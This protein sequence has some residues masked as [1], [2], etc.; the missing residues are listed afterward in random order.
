MSVLRRDPT[1]GRWVVFGDS[2]PPARSPGDPC[3]F[4]EGNE[5]MTP[6]EIVAWGRP[7]RR[8]NGPGW[9]V[10]VVP[11]ARPLLRIEA[12]L[13]RHADGIYD[14]TSGTGAHEIV[15][16]TAQHHHSLSALP[17]GQVALVLRAWAERMKDLKR[18]ARFRSIFLFKNQGARAGAWL[19]DH[20]H[21]QII[22]LPVI[23]KALKEMLEGARQHFRLK[24]RC[25]FC[26]ILREELDRGERVVQVTDR[27][28]ALAPYAS[29]YPFEFWIVPREHAADF[30]TIEPGAI[31][32]LAG[33]LRASLARFEDVL[34]EPAY[35]LF[36][37]SGPN[38][39]QRKGFWTTLAQDFHW[40]IQ[41]MP[42]S[43]QVA[44]FEVGSG[45]YA[46]PVLPEDAARM[47]RLG[48]P[49]TEQDGDVRTR[50]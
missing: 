36:L 7:D 41:V 50:T 11:N 44:G 1:T 39:D 2:P 30:E 20:A 34:P 33:L 9:Q 26:D 43:A 29:R 3:P 48:A 25:V 12:G 45:F 24:E 17:R 31:E 18:D 38:R 27:F 8:P 47:L 40:H 6:P 46:N 10:R 16:E 42:R 23:P 28:V 14:T 5:S 21:S 32:D 37:Y 13:E 49:R 35:N 4:C 15:I 19:P 22:G